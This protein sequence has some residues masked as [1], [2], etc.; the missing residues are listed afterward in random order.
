MVTQRSD[1]RWVKP[2]PECGKETS[3]LRKNYAQ[4]SFDLGKVCKSCSNKKTPNCHRGFHHLIRLS[5][6][7]KTKI[8]A[9]T[10]GLDFEI[11]LDDVWNL[12]T[13][14]KGLCRLS[15]LPIGWAEVGPNH[16]ASVDRIDSSIGYTPDNCQLLHKD[17]NMMKQAFNQQY[18]LDLCRAVANKTKW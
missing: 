5:W 18:F 17:V 7:N 9:E 11:T 2:C 10:R 12:Y 1:G 6:F 3:Y 13:K 15:G 16:T 8:S 14:Q 4:Y